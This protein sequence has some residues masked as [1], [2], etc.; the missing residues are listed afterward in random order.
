MEAL[1]FHPTRWTAFAMPETP[2]LKLTPLP[3]S[4]ESPGQRLTRIRRERGFTQIELVEKTGLIQTLVS[5]CERGKLRLSADVIL[6]FAGALEVPTDTLLQPPAEPIESK[7]PSRKVLRRAEQTEFLP[8]A[9][10]ITLLR[11][12]DTFLEG[13]ARRQ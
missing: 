8:S 7:K 12:S 3:P 9:Q 6:P 2:K 5:D 11:T 13:T 1:L 10:Q 4:D